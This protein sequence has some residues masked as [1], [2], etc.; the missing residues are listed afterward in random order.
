MRSVSPLDAL[1]GLPL[2]T[3]AL[4]PRGP[5]FTQDLR[6]R[7]SSLHTGDSHLGLN[8]D[9]EREEGARAPQFAKGS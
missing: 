8:E 9:V 4:S 5:F 3:A 1:P 6:G 7:R 2:P